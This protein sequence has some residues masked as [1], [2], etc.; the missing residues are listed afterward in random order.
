MYGKYVGR[1][2]YVFAPIRHNW[3]YD[4]GDINWHLKVFQEG[5]ITSVMFKFKG[6]IDTWVG[7][8]WSNIQGGQ[9]AWATL[10][11]Q[12]QFFHERFIPKLDEA[13]KAMSVWSTVEFVSLLATV[14]YKL[15]FN[16]RMAWYIAFQIVNT[17]VV[18]VLIEM[19][20]GVSCGSSIF[21]YANYMLI[22]AL[23]LTRY[24]PWLLTTSV[25]VVWNI[26][27]NVY[28]PN[29]TIGAHTWGL[30]TGLISWVYIFGRKIPLG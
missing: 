17:E 13:Y 15:G 11:R 22:L 7:E 14:I 19:G 21:N 5:S 12:D 29:I 1:L 25:F 23:W 4:T 30:L 24:D 6:M 10:V 26:F 3:L 28:Y 16:S 2:G 27:Q 20:H 8:G 9:Q 18:S